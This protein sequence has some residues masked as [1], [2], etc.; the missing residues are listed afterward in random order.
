MRTCCRCG[1]SNV[2]TERGLAVCDDCRFR[3]RKDGPPR[4]PKPRGPRDCPK[5]GKSKAITKYRAQVC[6]ECRIS[7]PDGSRKRQLKCCRECGSAYTTTGGNE[8]CARCRDA[9]LRH[10]CA[11][12]GAP[13]DKRAERCRVCTRKLQILDKAPGWKGGRR[14]NMRGYIMIMAPPNHPRASASGKYGRGYVRE[15]TLV[16]EEALGRYLQP[17]ETVH[18]KNGIKHDNRLENLELWTKAQPAGQRV[19]DLVAYARE[20]LTRYEA[21]AAL[22]AST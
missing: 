14:F 8:V 10:P 9:K 18:H 21:E 13:T 12:C 3:P 4:P 17:G 1:A 11:D 22:L 20:I 2:T 19:V 7:K 6:D 5:C 15:H 16:M